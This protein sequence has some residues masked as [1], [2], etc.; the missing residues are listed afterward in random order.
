[1]SKLCDVT[2]TTYEYITGLSDSVVTGRKPDSL[3]HVNN[4]VFL[5]VSPVSVNALLAGYLQCQ[6]ILWGRYL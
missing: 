3:M 1:M 5:E 4:L 2:G 6:Q